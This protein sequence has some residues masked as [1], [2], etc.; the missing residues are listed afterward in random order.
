MIWQN[1][2]LA[3]LPPLVSTRKILTIHSKW[4]VKAEKCSSKQT[5]KRDLNSL[6]IE[7]QHHEVQLYTTPSREKKHQLFKLI[8]SILNRIS[9][10][11][12]DEE[13][14]VFASQLGK[15]QQYSRF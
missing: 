11:F 7:K 6:E 5:E 2:A 8:H 13:T 15:E 14:H 1:N 12:W 3:I 4:E 10:T 9:V